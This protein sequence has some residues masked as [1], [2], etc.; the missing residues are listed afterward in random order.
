ME[1]MDEKHDRIDEFKQEIAEMRIRPPEDSSERM[2]LMAGILLPVLGLVAIFV[3]WWGASGSAY[4]AEQLPYVISGGILGLGLIVAGAALF[5]RYSM[6]R[7]MRFW[8]LRM[9][10]EER[11]QTDRTVEAMNEVESLLRAATRPRSKADG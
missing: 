4:P 9:V 8:L 10:Y 2:W 11:A 5:V 3:G 1:L 7:Y 6:T